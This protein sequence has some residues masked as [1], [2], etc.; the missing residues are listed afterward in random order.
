MDLHRRGIL[1][2]LG[3]EMIGARADVI[4][5]AE[6]RES[7][8]AAMTKIGLDVPRSSV[9]HNMQEARQVM[10]EVETRRGQGYLFRG[11]GAGTGVAE[12]R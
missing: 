10:Q 8:K 3:V 12:A 11:D 5:K 6:G 7:F 1:D 9:V 2:Q 4:A